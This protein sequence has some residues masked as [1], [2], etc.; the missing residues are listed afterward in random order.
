MTITNYKGEKS[1][2]GAVLTT[3]EENGYD[4]SD[5]YA[6]VWDE[7]EGRTKRVDYN[8]TRFAG[9]GTADIDATP[10]VIEKASEYV[11][12][13][14]IKELTEFDEVEAEEPTA[15]KKVK[16]VKGRKIPVGTEA[17]VKWGGK[18][19]NKFDY[20]RSSIF[21]ALVTL[22]DGSEVW[23][24]GKN[25]EV[26]DPDQYRKSE[27]EIEKEADKVKHV[28]HAPFARYPIF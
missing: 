20:N 27:T 10:E 26:I 2:K 3:R 7:A 21:R 18:M 19:K 22:P 24:N 28:W 1:Y 6:V 25:L 13:W 12:S 9:G 15:G 5:F 14:A 11:K 17:V 23:T 4:D 8:T 16:V